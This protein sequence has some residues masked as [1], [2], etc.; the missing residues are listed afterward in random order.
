MELSCC[1][2]PLDGDLSDEWDNNRESMLRFLEA[3]HWGVKGIVQDEKKM[4]IAD[5]EIIVDGID[6]NIRTSSRGEYWRLLVPATQY[7][8]KASSVGY[9]L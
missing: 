6:H 1:K 3:V 4:P 5:A 9:V 2:Y 8:I 7:F